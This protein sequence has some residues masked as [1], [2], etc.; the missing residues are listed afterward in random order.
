MRPTRSTWHSAS[1]TLCSRRWSGSPAAWPSREWRGRRSTASSAGWRSRSSS[2]SSGSWATPCHHHQPPHRHNNSTLNQTSPSS[3]RLSSRSSLRRSAR[4]PSSRRRRATGTAVRPPATTTSRQGRGRLAP[5]RTQTRDRFLIC[6][7]IY[8][9]C[10]CF[11]INSSC[12]AV[13][14]DFAIYKS[15]VKFLI[16]EQRLLAIRLAEHYSYVN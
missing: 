14:V 5:I 12:S 7:K 8:T 11:P 13:V 9:S 15:T 10:F 4:S 3:N 1:A 6:L 16:S 2:Q